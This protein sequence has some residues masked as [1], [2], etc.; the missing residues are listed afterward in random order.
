MLEKSSLQN[1]VIKN[2]IV[3]FD[4]ISF[5]VVYLCMG[6]NAIKY[7]V[8]SLP[9]IPYIFNFLKSK[10]GVSEDGEIVVNDK[11]EQFG[12]SILLH[13]VSIRKR[14]YY[15][16]YERPTGNKF[17]GYKTL[18]LKYIPKNEAEVP[19]FDER[20]IYLFNRMLELRFKDN[21]MMYI[22]ANIENGS[23]SIQESLLKFLALNNLGEDDVNFNST[24]RYIM[25]RMD[26]EI[27]TL[28]ER[29]IYILGIRRNKSQRRLFR[30]KDKGILLL[31][32][33]FESCHDTMARM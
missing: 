13:L 5:L 33:K 21:M 10:F 22:Y 17:E 20:G 16:I 18:Y 31:N 11:R 6:N 28:S 3:T 7:S 19:M 30:P 9:V 12:L 29:A 1:V 4:A 15:N 2:I 25:R 8:V 24:M 27:D 23:N 14:A 32:L 26:K